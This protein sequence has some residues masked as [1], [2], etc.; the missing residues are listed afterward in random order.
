MKEFAILLLHVNRNRKASVV[1]I[2]SVFHIFL[3]YRNNIFKKNVYIMINAVNGVARHFG[4]PPA[5]TKKTDGTHF[6]GI[7]FFRN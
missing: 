4:R 5:P 6:S 2:Y 7:W 3:H 1:K